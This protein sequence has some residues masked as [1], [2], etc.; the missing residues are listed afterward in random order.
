MSK[1]RGIK[2]N[3]LKMLLELGKSHHPREFLGILREQNGVIAELDLIPG[4]VN[5][6][7]SASLSQAMI[8]LDPRMTGSVHSHPNGIISPSLGDLKF[9]PKMGRYH[10]II[11][12]PYTDRDWKCFTARGEPC[13][14]EVIP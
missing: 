7:E 4:T 1:I 5:R 12:H 2:E 11:G 13:T 9:F 3:L 8:P 14:L 6:E 10:L